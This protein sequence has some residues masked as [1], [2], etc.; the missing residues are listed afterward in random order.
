MK[1]AQK[2]WKRV[3]SLTL[4]LILTF[5]M[6]PMTDVQ[7]ESVSGGNLT[8]VGRGKTSVT[9]TVKKSL[10][11]LEEQLV[12]LPKQ[13]Y[14]GHY[15]IAASNLTVTK[16]DGTEIT[17]SDI[18]VA[19]TELKI[20]ADQNVGAASLTLTYTPDDEENDEVFVKEY[21]T[22][23]NAVPVKVA[24]D[25]THIKT[26]DGTSV[27]RLLNTPTISLDGGAVFDGYVAPTLIDA[28]DYTFT[29]DD[30]NAGDRTAIL[31]EACKLVLSDVAHYTL[32]NDRPVINV[33]VEKRVLTEA[34]VLISNALGKAYDGTSEAVITAE[35]EGTKIVGSELND[36]SMSLNFDATYY[37]GNEE[38]FGDPTSNVA[39]DR[40][41]LSNLKVMEGSDESPNYCFATGM[42]ITHEANCE[43]TANEGFLEFTDMESLGTAVEETRD[44]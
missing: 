32:A 42:T 23:V 21:S 18:F 15:T 2:V 17:A 29:L 6:I 20:K 10:Y 13:D 31:D 22:T 4:A 19:E 1:Y 40:V 14:E 25:G 37:T 34:D 39:A 43:I 5:G 35:L 7:A 24:W 26:Y 30:V 12:T 33:T 8:A 9:A 27:F 41:I 38:E 36:K 3:L 11:W 44:G 28:G 16:T